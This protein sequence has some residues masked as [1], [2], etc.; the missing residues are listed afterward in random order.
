MMCAVRQRR[1]KWLQSVQTPELHH[2]LCPAN[3]T[4]MAILSR[5]IVWLSDQV[6]RDQLHLIQSFSFLL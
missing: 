3:G 2:S 6:S 4:R 1:V 5:D